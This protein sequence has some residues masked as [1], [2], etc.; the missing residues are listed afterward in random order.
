REGYRQTLATM[1]RT[2]E[3]DSQPE[4]LAAVLDAATTSPDS[5][6]TAD[7]LLDLAKRLQAGDAKY[8]RLRHLLGAL[9][10]RAGQHAESARHLREA[11]AGK[12]AFPEQPVQSRYLLAMAQQHLG[13]H[14]E[15][16]KTLA[17][18]VAVHEALT[19]RRLAEGWDWQS[20]AWVERLVAEL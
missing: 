3:R 5:D 16:R 17:A 18:A 10:L 19:P 6:V 15:A 8:P 14:E 20:G 12:Q 9:H 13:Q 11:L 1:F 2:L 7:R 4:N